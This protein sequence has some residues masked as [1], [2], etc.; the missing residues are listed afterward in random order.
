[1]AEKI[2]FDLVS[3]EKIVMSRPVDMVVI[4]GGDGDFGVLP[5]HAPLLSTVRAGVISVYENGVIVERVVVAGGFAEVTGDRVNIVAEEAV[6]VSDLQYD[7]VE[8]ELRNLEEDLEDAKDADA[9]A[10]VEHR[11]HLSKL[12]L[13]ALA[14]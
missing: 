1:M 6:L 11:I 10:L 9:R 4:P 2:T 3:P 13:H 7:A 8:Q 12:K 14:A 5:R